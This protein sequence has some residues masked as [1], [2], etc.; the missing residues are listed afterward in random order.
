M[1]QKNNKTYLPKCSHVKKCFPVTNSTIFAE[2]KHVF[3][4]SV[5]MISNCDVGRA[6]HV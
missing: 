6:K 5:K 4:S 2:D 3:S 1:S